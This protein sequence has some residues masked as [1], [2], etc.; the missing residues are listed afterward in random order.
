[1]ERAFNDAYKIHIRIGDDTGAATAVH[2]LGETYYARSKHPEAEKTFKVA[3]EIYSRIGVQV[4]VANSLRSLGYTY[5]GQ[6]RGQ[7]AELSFMEAHKIYSRIGN[8]LGIRDTSRALKILHGDRDEHE[9]AG[10]SNHQGPVAHAA[11]GGEAA[12]R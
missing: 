5:R 7:E 6:A 8:S 9:P 2:G 3:H 12:K 4:G 11:E 1:A 10:T